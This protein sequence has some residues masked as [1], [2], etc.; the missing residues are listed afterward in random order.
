MI[1]IFP[2]RGLYRRALKYKSALKFTASWTARFL[3]L[4]CYFTILLNVRALYINTDAIK[5]WSSTLCEKQYVGLLLITEAVSVFI[6]GEDPT[7]TLRIPKRPQIQSKPRMDMQNYTGLSQWTLG[8]SYNSNK[9]T[10][11]CAW[12]MFYIHRAS[13]SWNL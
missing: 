3:I 10:V 8:A 1:K 6:G 2:Y 12:P 7:F 13:R 11:A 5:N 9:F 4:I